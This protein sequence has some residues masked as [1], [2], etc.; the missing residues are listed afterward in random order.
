MTGNSDWPK[1][2]LQTRHG[3]IIPLKVRVRKLD[4]NDSFDLMRQLPSAIKLGLAEA[5]RLERM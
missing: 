4:L 5:Q 1:L 3:R 2:V